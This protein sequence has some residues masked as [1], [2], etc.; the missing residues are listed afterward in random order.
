MFFEFPWKQRKVRRHW[1]SESW[2][3]GIWKNSVWSIWPSYP[4]VKQALDTWVHPGW[5]RRNIVFEK[6]SIFTHWPIKV[7]LTFWLLLSPNSI[8]KFPFK[9]F[10]CSSVRNEELLSVLDLCVAILVANASYT[11]V[12]K[13][14]S[15]N[16]HS[17]CL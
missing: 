15:L 9:P 1:L 17:C 2:L 16:K 14:K 6:L 10:K 8:I 5:C 7:P 12:A 4:Q 13:A 3:K 11:H